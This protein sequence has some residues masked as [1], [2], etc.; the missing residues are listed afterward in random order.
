MTLKVGRRSVRI[1]SADKILFPDDGIT[2]ADLAN[3]YAAVAPAMVEH[4]RDRPLNLWRWNTGI[5]NDV[6]IQQAIP[7]GAP[8]WVKR[9]TV[10]RRRGGDVDARGR[11]RG[12]HARL[13]REPELHHAARVDA[14]GR[15]SPTSLTASSSTSIR[16]TT[17]TSVST[18]S[19]RAR[20]R[21]ATCCARRVCSR[22][23]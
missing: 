15:T 18:R 12:R 3:Y 1:S 11:R 16:R 13:A 5:D 22:L 8:D 20:S 4:V 23:R 9:V 21:S 6:V 14:R 10:A 19:A 17:A 7:K 2:K